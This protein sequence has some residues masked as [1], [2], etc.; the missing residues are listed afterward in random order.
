MMIDFIIGT[1]SPN[2]YNPVGVVD[3][4]EVLSHYNHSK[5]IFVCFAIMAVVPQIPWRLLKK[6][7]WTDLGA[8]LL[9]CFYLFRHMAL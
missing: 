8:Q 4:R 1:L 7:L 2:S 9:L 5:N 6:V 3:F